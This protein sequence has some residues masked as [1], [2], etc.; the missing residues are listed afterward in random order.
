MHT[1]CL[2]AFSFTP[3]DYPSSPPQ[4]LQQFKVLVNQRL[5]I[6]R[7]PSTIENN[8]KEFPIVVD[9]CVN[10]NT[11]YRNLYTLRQYL[12]QF[13]IYIPMLNSCSRHMIDAC[14]A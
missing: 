7:I 1:F 3:S 11:I 4:Q 13:H 14:P 8:T 2:I 12:T 9:E 10:F 6:K 5:T